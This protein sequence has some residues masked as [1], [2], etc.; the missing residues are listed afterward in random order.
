[1][2]VRSAAIAL[3][4]ATLPSSR[5]SAFQVTPIGKSSS[6]SSS[7]LQMSSEVETGTTSVVNEPVPSIATNENETRKKNF[8]ERMMAKAPQEGQ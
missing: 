3:L 1:M 4:A 6:F 5:V 8:T 2:K 7:L